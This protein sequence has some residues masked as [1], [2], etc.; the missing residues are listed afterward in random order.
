MKFE[1]TKEWAKDKPILPASISILLVSCACQIHRFMQHLLFGSEFRTTLRVK[2][3][4][5]WIQYYKKHRLIYKALI[6]SF[7]PD[8]IDRI[9]K[10]TTAQIILHGLNATPPERI[11]LKNKLAELSES[12]V[13]NFVSKVNTLI[14]DLTDSVFVDIG[15]DE[16]EESEK[17]EQW[18][19]ISTIPEVLFFFRVWLPCFFLYGERPTHLIRKARQGKID[20]I[21]KLMWLD[22]NI[23]HDSQI[24]KILE[25]ASS[26][27]DNEYFIS[28]ATALSKLPPKSFSEESIKISIAGI[29]ALVFES[30]GSKISKPKIRELFNN[31]AYDVDGLVNDPDLELMEVDN[32]RMR[33]NSQKK[34]WLSLFRGTINKN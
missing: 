31:L 5:R 4:N 6:E 9:S 29:I 17:L 1:N 24:A 13:K 3:P 22:K 16:P 11:K 25:N 28:I 33:V 32:F 20:S 8:I 10:T 14:T 18:K 2:D 19:N 27:T 15:K 26:E 21:E 12:E 30:F 34:F 23:V 7:L